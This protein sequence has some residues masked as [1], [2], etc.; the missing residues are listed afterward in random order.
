MKIAMNK[1]VLGVIISES[2]RKIRGIEKYTVLQHK[3]HKTR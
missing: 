3:N 2:F 1:I